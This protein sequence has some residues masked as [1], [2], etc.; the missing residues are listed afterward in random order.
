MVCRSLHQHMATKGKIDLK[1]CYG[2]PASALDRT[3]CDRAQLQLNAR[4][5]F[6]RTPC[7]RVPRAIA[8]AGPSFHRFQPCAVAVMCVR[9]QGV[10]SNTWPAF[11]RS[12]MTWQHTSF[13]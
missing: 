3:K 5:K 11:E 10:R 8:L 13:V 9:L 7:R 6:E 12:P 4:S 1:R 2:A